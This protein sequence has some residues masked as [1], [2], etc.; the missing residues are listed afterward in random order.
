VQISNISTL[1]DGRTALRQDRN[2]WILTWITIMYLPISLT[3]VR[4]TLCVG[5]RRTRANND[6]AV[7]AIPD[8]QKV[9]RPGLKLTWYLTIIGIL[10]VFT[11]SLAFGMLRWVTVAAGLNY[12][13][14]RLAQ[15][16]R[17]KGERARL[18]FV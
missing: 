16:W 12:I 14:M 9:L 11:V 5:I 15:L 17:A 4:M 18:G 10:S 8:E 13:W 6:Q 1:E 2:I 3:T 7:F